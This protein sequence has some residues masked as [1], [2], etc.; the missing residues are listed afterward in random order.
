MITLIIIC[1]LIG[2]FAGFMS[3]MF[4]IGGDTVSGIYFDIEGK[5]GQTNTT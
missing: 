2:L 5:N 4:G 3:G 1:L